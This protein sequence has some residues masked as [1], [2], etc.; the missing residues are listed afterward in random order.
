LD[1]EAA[2]FVEPERAVNVFRRVG[3]NEGGLVVDGD[4]GVG[5]WGFGVVVVEGFEVFL[6]LEGRVEL[7]E[8]FNIAFGGQVT[9]D[10]LRLRGQEGDQKPCRQLLFLGEFFALLHCLTLLCHCFLG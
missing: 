10:S 1:K 7:G 4:G 9:G 2:K 3:K 5:G 8:S 6:E